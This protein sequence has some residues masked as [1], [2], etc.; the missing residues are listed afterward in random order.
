[1]DTGDNAINAQEQQTPEQI[2]KE[3]GEQEAA[4]ES[5]PPA[6]SQAPAA[7]AQDNGD[8]KVSDIQNRAAALSDEERALLKQIPELVHLV[9][10]TVGR[11]GSLQSELQRIGKAAAAQAAD[12]PT[13]RQINQAAGDPEAWKKLK[14]DFPDWAEGVESLI[15]ARI[16]SAQPQVEIDKVLDERIARIKA[17]WRAEREREAEEE[18]AEERPDWKE[19]VSS[20]EFA[21][22]LMQQPASYAKRALESNR[23]S[24][25]LK[26][27]S[28][29][30]KSRKQ[31]KQEQRPNRLA[32]AAIPSGSAKPNITKSVE[33]MTPEEYW[34]YLGEQERKAAR[35]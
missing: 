34:A 4:G 3:L 20:K 31:P 9:K 29:F 28:D 14:E 1:M 11:V 5:P 33:D 19:V 8:E 21:D 27:L 25:V 13:D 10:T 22:W 35:A 7:S 32:S 15:A 12:S 17:E 26:V 2:W 6:A 24:V 23:P 30:D 16:P 18:I